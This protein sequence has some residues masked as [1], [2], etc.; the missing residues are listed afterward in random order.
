MSIGRVTTD[1]DYSGDQERAI[2]IATINPSSAVE[3]IQF[4]RFRKI[5]NRL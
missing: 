2:N 5:Y 1:N 4:R 3:R